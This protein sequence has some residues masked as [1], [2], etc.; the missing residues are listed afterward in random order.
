MLQHQFLLF[1][2]K[3]EAPDGRGPGTPRRSRQLRR[4]PA[5][6]RSAPVR[7]LVPPAVRSQRSC[8]QRR[9]PLL[10]AGRRRRRRHPP[11]TAS[12]SSVSAEHGHSGHPRPQRPPGLPGGQ[13]FAELALQLLLEPGDRRGGRPQVAQSARGAAGPGLTCHRRTKVA[14]R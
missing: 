7:L 3:M 14:Q 9:R 13:Q 4:L 6:I 10:P 5:S 8:P 12:I 2:N 1:Q 11:E